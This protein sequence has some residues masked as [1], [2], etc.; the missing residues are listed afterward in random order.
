MSGKKLPVIKVVAAVIRD[1]SGRIFATQRGYGDFKDK[2]EFPGGKVEE[3]ETP[4]DALVREIREELRA[5]ITVGDLIT[6][7]EYDYPKFHL[8]MDCFYADLASEGGN[9][10][11]L[12]EHEAARWLLPGELDQVDW[13]PAD[14]EVVKILSDPMARI[15]AHIRNKYNI[16]PDYPWDGHDYAVYRHEDNRKWFALVM[17]VR[18]D[19]LYPGDS[20]DVILPVI[21]LKIPDPILHNMLIQEEGIIPS[22]HMNK[23]NW[24]TVLLDGTV[25]QEEVYGLIKVSYEATASA[26]RRHKVR[27]PKEW[28]I[29]SNPKYYDVISAFE[30]NEEIDWKQGAGI[31]VGDTVYLYVAAPVSA[32]LYKCRVTQTD[33]PYDFDNGALRIR[34][35]MKIRLLKRYDKDEFTFEV[36]REEYGINAIRGPRG[37]PYSLSE[38]L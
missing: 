2:W 11:T 5:A 18:K 24:I 4:K 36:L 34:A 32:I 35:L 10:L 21:N 29:P 15:E 37:V 38:K 19:R 33:I 3:G 31:N 30:E 16:A 26:A 12:T 8:S 13:L 14:V 22:Y 20:D 17:C 25:D 27:D 9:E 6:T 7:V 1:C 23:R 28:I